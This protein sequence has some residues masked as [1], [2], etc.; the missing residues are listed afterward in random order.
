MLL[1]HRSL[2]LKPNEACMYGN[3]GTTLNQTKKL[4]GR[5]IIEE[6]RGRNVPNVIEQTQATFKTS[7]T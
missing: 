4:D 2:L 1:I 3:R 6:V 5:L 7:I